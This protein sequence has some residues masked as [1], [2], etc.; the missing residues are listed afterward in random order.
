MWC[1][2]G[3]NLQSSH[4]FFFNFFLLFLVKQI[5]V[6][7]FIYLF[8]FWGDGVSTF[9]FYC[10]GGS[11]KFLSFQVFKFPSFQGREGGPII[12]LE[13]ILWSK[14]QWEALKKN[15]T[16][17]RKQTD[18]RTDRMIDRHGDS[19]I[20]IAISFAGLS[21]TSVSPGQLSTAPVH[22][23]FIKGLRLNHS[24]ELFSPDLAL[25]HR[26]GTCRFQ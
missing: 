11:S 10:G 26:Q 17:W 14:G 20:D 24:G 3:S 4:V 13:L 1:C 12:G 25:S 18:R 21:L 8:L 2:I 9:P 16:W 7:I 5:F 19:M 15:C 23:I 6:N 22:K